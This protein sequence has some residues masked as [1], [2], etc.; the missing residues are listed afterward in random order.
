[1]TSQAAFKASYAD[2]KLIKTRGVVSISFEVPL[3]AADAAYKVLDGMPDH[4]KELWVAIAKLKTDIP[5]KEKTEPN[6][7]VQRAGILCGDEQFQTFLRMTWPTAYNGFSDVAKNDERA[8]N[9]IRQLC[10]ISSRK[11]I[12]T[13][14]HASAKFEDMIGK[15]EAWRRGI[16]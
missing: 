1:M 14:P 8:A 4:G 2:W 11:E 15:Y 6:R 9:V 13:N 10:N 5:V 3:E 12:A 16:E 7:L